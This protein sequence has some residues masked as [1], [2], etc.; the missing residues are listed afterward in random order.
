MSDRANIADLVLAI[1]CE[2]AEKEEIH[3]KT[4]KVLR[5]IG[6]RNKM[7]YPTLNY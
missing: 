2:E 3:Q 4:D 7:S 5:K 6:T 1:C